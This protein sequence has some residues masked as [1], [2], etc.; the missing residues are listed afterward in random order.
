MDKSHEEQDFQNAADDLARKQRK[1]PPL[2]HAS[3][4]IRRLLARKEFSQIGQRKELEQAWLQAAGE[5]LSSRAQCGR[6]VS[7][8]LEVVVKDSSTLTQLTFEKQGLLK[9]LK[10]IEATAQIK[11]LRFRLG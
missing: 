10:Q 2:P 9:R 8:T 6:L 4:V 3:N 11:N 5:E 7:G 1:P